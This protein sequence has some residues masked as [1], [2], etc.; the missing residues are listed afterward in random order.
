MIDP[1]SITLNSALPVLCIASNKLNY[2]DKISPWTPNIK[3]PCSVYYSIVNGYD[4]EKNFS[5]RPPQ[6]ENE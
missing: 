1:D 4:L 2:F 3:Y 5:T 6:S